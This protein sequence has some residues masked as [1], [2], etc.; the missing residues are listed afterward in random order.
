MAVLL[1]G[2]EARLGHA[3]AALLPSDHTLIAQICQG[4]EAALAL[5]YD[6]YGRLLYTIALRITGDR[7]TSEEVIQDVFQGVWQSAEGFQLESLSR[8]WD[9]DNPHP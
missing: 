9:D 7:S 2:D 3:P 8:V 6:R 4:Q 1:D 5:L